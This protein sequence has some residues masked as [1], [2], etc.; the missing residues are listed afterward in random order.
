M[1]ALEIVELVAASFE[2]KPKDILSESRDADLVVARRIAM[3]LIRRWLR[4]SFPQIGKLFKRDHTT[5]ITACQTI[6]TQMSVHQERLSRL[7]DYIVLRLSDARACDSCGA[8]LDKKM[9][10]L[11]RLKTEAAVIQKQIAELEGK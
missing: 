5:V 9:M 11:S 3:H 2:L 8:V 10:L 4:W 1:T 7:D 6:E